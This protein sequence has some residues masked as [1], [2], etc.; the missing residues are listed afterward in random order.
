MKRN[1]ELVREIL[2]KIEEATEPPN[3]SELLLTSTGDGH[4]ARLA[5]HIQML[6]EEAGFV[7]GIDAS[8]MDGPDWINLELTWQGHDFLATVRNPEVWRRTKDGV[9]KVGEVSI[10]ILAQMAKAYLKQVIKEH[11]GLDLG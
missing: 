11:T 1:M 7:R 4:E 10:D 8:S 5:Y 6:V 9:R 2:L 3:M